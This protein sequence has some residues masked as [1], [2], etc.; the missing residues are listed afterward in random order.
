MNN[1]DILHLAVCSEL[2]RNILIS[3]NEGKKPLADLRD[4]LNISSTTAIHALRELEKNSL[5]FQEKDKNYGLTNTGRVI[6]LKLLDFNNAAEILK[7]H[8]RFWLEHDLSGIPEHMMEKIGCLKDSVLI[9]NTETDI[10]K[11]HLNF[12]SLLKKAKDIRGVSPFLI[13]EFTSLFEELIFGKSVDIQLLLTREVYEKL[14]KGILKKIFTEKDT[15][16]KLYVTKENLKVAFTVTDYFL[17]IGFFHTGGLYDFSNDLIS[18]SEE[19]SA[20]GGELFEHYV[21]LSERVVL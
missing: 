21:K 17:S 6:T 16:F 5:V 3:L 10:F 11:V 12:I 8:E 2:R 7:K 19:A 20:W 1:K 13:P 15:R 9:T 18:Y 14:D 4:G